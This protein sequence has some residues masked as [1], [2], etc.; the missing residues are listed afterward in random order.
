MASPTAA[1]ASGLL[2]F[3][4][5]GGRLRVE[6]LGRWV[7]ANAEVLDRLL[8]AMPAPDGR[9]LD[10]DFTAI[11]AVDTVGAW[12]VHR[13]AARWQAAGGQAAIR[14]ASPEYEVLLGQVA[15]ADRPAPPKPKKLGP[16]AAMLDRL[17]RRVVYIWDD[18]LR[19]ISFLGE[20]VAAMCRLAFVHPG[21][22]R[23]TSTF[24]QA[25]AVGIEAMPI[26]GLISFL[27]GVV[28][29]YQGVDQLAM[30]GAQI[31]VV[32]LVAISVLRELGILL[33]AI[34]IAGRSG[35]SFT[36]QIGAMKLNEEVDAM[37]TLGLDPI[38]VL[39][40]PRV[41]ALMVMLPCLAVFADFMGLLGGMLMSWVTLGISPDVFMNRLA[42]AV[43]WKTYFVGVVKAPFFAVTIAVVG[44]LEGLRVEGSSESVGRR[45][46]QSVVKGIFLVI[47]LD[48]AFSIFFATI[49][50]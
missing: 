14:G 16:F 17:G 48:A 36:A 39:V 5:D 49:G 21:R 27:I 33:T 13:T 37:R 50:I 31:F 32:N 45:T 34:V 24:A 47:V 28:I 15:K 18:M 8:G 40:V 23:L 41:V 25:Q 7:V 2:R 42:A 44:C 9:E 11:E 6:L 38:E 12:L 3:N 4:E 10:I 30:F 1:A 22:F 35:S 20:T 19:L 29:S 43:T 46:T 26:V